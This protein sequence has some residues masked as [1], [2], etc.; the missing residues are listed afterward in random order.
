[1][2]IVTKSDLENKEKEYQKMEEE[3]VNLRKELEKRKDELKLRTNYEGSTDALDKML[4]KQKHSK[5]TKGVG[6][7][8]GQCFNSKDSS[9]KEILFTS[10][11]ESEVKQTFPVSKPNEKKTYVVA[12]KNKSRNPHADPKRKAKMDDGEFDKVRKDFK[13][14]KKSVIKE[15]DSLNKNIEE[16]NNNLVALT[17]S[18][19]EDKRMYEVTKSDLENKEKEYQKTEEEIVNLRKELEKCKDELEVRTK[20][21]DNTNALDKM[22]SKQKHSKDI[23]GVG[24]EGGQC[25]NSKDS[26]DKEILFT[27]SSEIEVK[28]TFTV[29][30]LNEKK[31]Y[32]SATKN[33]SRNQHADPKRKAKMDDGGFTRFKD[34]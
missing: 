22:L 27:S 3:I 11:S 5:D 21:E 15:H 20:Y 7:E 10:S 1:M 34:T 30:K 31:T 26:S 19:D 12:T 2:Y 23:E 25:S 4:S 13:K 33:Q 28:Q 8:A 17:T 29:S 24:V 9:N 18:L 14:Y 16:S 6:L 32:D